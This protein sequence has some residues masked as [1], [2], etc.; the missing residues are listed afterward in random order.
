MF[1]F[2][3]YNSTHIIFGKDRLDNIS[4]LVPEQAFL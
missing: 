3:F 2:S 1:N 4:K